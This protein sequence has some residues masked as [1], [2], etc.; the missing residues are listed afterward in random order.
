MGGQRLL[1]VYSARADA[2]V[3]RAAAAAGGFRQLI[4]RIR[5]MCLQLD[6][7]GLQGS[8]CPLHELVL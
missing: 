6:L 7:Y 4:L 1:V 2:A 3:L 8:F 5:T